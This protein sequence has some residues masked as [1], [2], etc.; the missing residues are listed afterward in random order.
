MNKLKY[1]LK[2]F[3]IESAFLYGE[4]FALALTYYLLKALTSDL[5]WFACIGS[6][7]VYFIGDYDAWKGK[8]V[9]KYEVE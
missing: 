4:F 6:I 3:L 7:G 9:K 8:I 5:M 2:L 1:P